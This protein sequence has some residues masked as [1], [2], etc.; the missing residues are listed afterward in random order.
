M[1][2]DVSV[3]SKVA[4]LLQGSCIV[5][6]GDTRVLEKMSHFARGVDILIHDCSRSDSYLEKVGFDKH[7]TGLIA[8][9]KIVYVVEVRIVVMIYFSVVV[10]GEEMLSQMV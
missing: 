8:L 6:S 10:C 3:P 1:D 4:H 7:H 9:G 5:F 2:Q